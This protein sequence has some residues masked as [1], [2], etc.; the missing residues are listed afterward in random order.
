M[1]NLRAFSLFS[2]AGGFDLGFEAAGMD[3]V[4]QVEWDKYCRDVLSFRWPDVPRWFDVRD[5]CGADLPEFD[6]LIFGSPCQD[7]SRAGSGVGFDGDRSSLFWEAI[8][9]LG[10]VFDNDGRPGWVVWENVAGALGSS[11]GKDFGAV[12]GALADCGAVDI[13][14]RVCDSQWFG[15]PQRRRRVFVVARFGD[16]RRGGPEILSFDKGLRGNSSSLEKKVS[17]NSW[18]NGKQVTQTLDAVLSKGQ[19]LPEKSRFP[20]FAIDAHV[21]NEEIVESHAEVLESLRLLG[22]TDAIPGSLLRRVSPLEAERLMGWPDNWTRYGASGEISNTQRFKMC[23]N[24][25]V[26]P[27][28]EQIAKNIIDC[29]NLCEML[30]TQ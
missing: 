13:E 19:M 4:G 29:E 9:I 3:I 5:V 15:V 12:L 22:L 23:G 1:K 27:V 25:V 26:A 21:E 30:R 7:L 28:A 20:V 16:R 18:W 24:G 17:R 10:E 2:G 14:W 8:R 6:V 11:G